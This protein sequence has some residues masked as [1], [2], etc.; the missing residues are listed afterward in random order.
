MTQ[1]NIKIARNFDP[2]EQVKKYTVSVPEIVGEMY[3]KYIAGK[4]R[5]NKG[6]FSSWWD[7]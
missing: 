5:V 4:A 3:A 7:T 2:E 1:R 6:A